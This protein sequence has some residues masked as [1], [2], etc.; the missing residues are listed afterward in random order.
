M[1]RGAEWRV[2]TMD[3]QRAETLLDRLDGSGSR[4]EREAVAEL[5]AVG[6]KLPTLLR[7]KYHATRSWKTRSACVFYSMKYAR[8]SDDAVALGREALR[9]RATGVRYRACKIGR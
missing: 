8:D 6:Q 4:D 9:D 5:R 7:K 2:W 3:E 1:P